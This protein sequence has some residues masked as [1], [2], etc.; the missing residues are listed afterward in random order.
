MPCKGEWGT[1]IHI[2]KCA[3]ITIR[4]WIYK[5]YGLSPRQE[6]FIDQHRMPDDLTDAWTVIRHPVD[7]IRSFYGY[8]SNNH[9]QWDDLPQ[10]I[11]DIFRPYYGMW[12]PQFVNSVALE[13]PN[14][15]MKV[16]DH[17]IVD[18]VRWYRI[19]EIDDMFR[20]FGTGLQLFNI[21]K[22]DNKPVMT[23]EM[24]QTLLWSEN[25]TIKKYGYE[26]YG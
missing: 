4:E 17:Y 8:M 23:E 19:E 20:H 24:R 26:N 11:H 21:H 9:W 13:Q 10:F 6:D 25:L 16:Y 12:F 7:W 15:V 3:G 5:Q 22:T 1:F 14:A 2:P 18:G